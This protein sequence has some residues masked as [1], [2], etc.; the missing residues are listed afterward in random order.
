MKETRLVVVNSEGETKKIEKIVGKVTTSEKEDSENNELV[1][2]LARV[3]AASKRYVDVSAEASEKTSHALQ[4]ERQARE[5]K[6]SARRHIKRANSIEKTTKVRMAILGVLGFLGGAAVAIQEVLEQHGPTVTTK[7][8]LEATIIYVVA[9]AIFAAIFGYL[10]YSWSM[11]RI[12]DHRAAASEAKKTEKAL[13]MQAN[14]CIIET[15]ELNDLSTK[16]FEN[17]M[18]QQ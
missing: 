5:A 4:L 2:K 9:G 18:S 15:A 8:T 10:S 17:F 1:E 12:N 7:G 13:K 6:K 14:N 16:A 3:L 11:Q